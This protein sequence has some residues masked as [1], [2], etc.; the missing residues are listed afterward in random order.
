MGETIFNGSDVEPSGVDG[1]PLGPEL[2]NLPGD[3]FRGGGQVLAGPLPAPAPWFRLQLHLKAR[4]TLRKRT[5]CLLRLRTKRVET[6]DS[7][8]RRKEVAR[9]G[10][11]APQELPISFNFFNNFF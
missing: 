4:F 3:S 8:A 7:Q 9:S 1:T 10:C 6:L 5:R 2:A 11:N